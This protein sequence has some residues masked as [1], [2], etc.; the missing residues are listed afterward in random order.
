MRFLVFFWVAVEL[1]QIVVIGM[2]AVGYRNLQRRLDSG[3]RFTHHPPRS[4]TDE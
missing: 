2:L 4:V 1:L 3:E